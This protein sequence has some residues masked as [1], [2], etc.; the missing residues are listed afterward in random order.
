MARGMPSMTA[1]LALLAVAGYQN[2][3]KISDMLRKAGAAGDPS[4][5]GLDARNSQSISTVLSDIGA[6]FTGTSG[7]GALSGGLAG[8]VD[9][10]RGQGQAEAA[11]S[12]V[13][14][15]DN[16]PVAAQDLEAALGEDTI[17]EL[18]AKTGLSRETLLERLS[19]VIPEAVHDMTPDGRLPTPD[20]AKAYI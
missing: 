10:F 13:A 9:R 12:W 7:P 2:R 14:A 16:K 18:S 17:A 5:T 6:F 15:G 8:L 11:E 4:A 1:L 20:D 19:R 3:D